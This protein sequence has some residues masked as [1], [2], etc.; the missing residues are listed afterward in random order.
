MTLIIREDEDSSDSIPTVLNLV[1]RNANM[2][3]QR[4][5]S[6]A[7]ELT[8]TIKDEEKTHKSKHLIYEPYCVHADEP[9]I[10]KLVHSALEEFKGEPTDIRVRINLEVL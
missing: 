5:S 1:K 3:P 7:S 10:R 2:S 4:F 8:I 6:S 9:V